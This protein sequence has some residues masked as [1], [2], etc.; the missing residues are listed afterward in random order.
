MKILTAFSIVLAL[1]PILA[2]ATGGESCGCCPHCGCNETKTVCRLVPQVT[3]K[4]KIEYE[5]KCEDICVPGRSCF[6]GTECVTDCNGCTHEEKVYQPTCGKVYTKRTLVKKTTTVE[7]CTYKC[8]AETV[9]C[10]C[11]CSCGGSGTGYSSHSYAPTAPQI[12]HHVDPHPVHT[13]TN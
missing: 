8:V 13:Q 12:H 4:P 6:V 5:C 2:W 3:K 1:I 9:C 7:S 10:N 11:G